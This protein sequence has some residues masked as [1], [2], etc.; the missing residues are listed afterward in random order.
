MLRFRLRVTVGDVIAVGPGKIALLEAIHETGSITGAAKRLDMSYRRAWLL[1]DEMNRSL[2]HP[3]V[4]SAKGGVAGGGSALTDAGRR[5]IA[6]YR[7][8]EQTASAA[9]GDDI[10]ELMA[11]LAR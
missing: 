1:L 11:M 7:H 5:L 4:D 3:V 6:L 2:R 10:H 9:C 8:I